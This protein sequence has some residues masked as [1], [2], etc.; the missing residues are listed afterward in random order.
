MH[1]LSL[2]INAQLSVLYTVDSAFKDAPPLG[3]VRALRSQQKYIYRVGLEVK[4]LPE[5]YS[6][7]FVCASTEGW[8]TAQMGR[9]SERWLL[10]HIST[11]ISCIGSKLV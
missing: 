4:L 10:V 8:E 9:L 3:V 11:K 7:H 5:T 2:N 1:S 6:T